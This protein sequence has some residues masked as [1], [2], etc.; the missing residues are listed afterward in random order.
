[1]NKQCELCGGQKVVHV[2]LGF[3]MSF[4]PCPQCNEKYRQKMGFTTEI[5]VG[6]KNETV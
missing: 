6:E 3:G 1:M 5:N 4:G 2:D